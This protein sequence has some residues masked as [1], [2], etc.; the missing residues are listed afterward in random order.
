MSKDILPL[1]EVLKQIENADDDAISQIIQAVIRRYK[2]VY[3]GWE[4]VF[5]SLPLDDAAQR[6]K[7]LAD[8]IEFLDRHG[9]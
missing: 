1:Q 5:L 8:L 9:Q 4:V 6:R 7:Q 2:Q 3:P